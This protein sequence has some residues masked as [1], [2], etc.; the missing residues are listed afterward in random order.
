M[1]IPLGVKGLTR[2]RR[3]RI[4]HKRKG[5]FEGIFLRKQKSPTPFIDPKAPTVN[6]GVTP[7][8][9]CG[10]TVVNSIQ[11]RAEGFQCKTCLK[12]DVELLVFAIDTRDGSGSE[13][14]R[15]SR[16]AQ[17][18]ETAI[19]PSLITSIGPAKGA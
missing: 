5:S 8:P 17:S 7:C 12:A 15:R 16:D 18:I 10:A 9:T 3:Y 19:R 4:E 6:K 11:T 13:W 2:R 1:A 14:L